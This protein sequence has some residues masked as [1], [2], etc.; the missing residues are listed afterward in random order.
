MLLKKRATKIKMK[1]QRERGK[2]VSC[3][4]D[5]PPFRRESANSSPCPR[6]ARDV[7][8]KKINTVKL[9]FLE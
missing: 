8:K 9:Q 6:I 3:A 5:H 7:K 2:E 4:G 1:T